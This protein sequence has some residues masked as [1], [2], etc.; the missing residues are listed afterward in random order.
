MKIKST[1]FYF[2]G[3][4]AETMEDLFLSWKKAF[5]KYDTEIKREDYFTKPK[6]LSIF[7]LK[8]NENL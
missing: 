5:L 1:L 7:L 4:L 3:V 6:D 2:D 8:L